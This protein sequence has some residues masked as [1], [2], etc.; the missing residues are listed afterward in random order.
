MGYQEI[1]AITMCLEIVEIG[2][3]MRLNLLRNKP[4]EYSVSFDE[5]LIDLNYQRVYYMLRFLVPVSMIMWIVSFGIGDTEKIQQTNGILF[6]S[7]AVLFL[8]SLKYPLQALQDDRYAKK[9]IIYTTYAVLLYWGTDLYGF[10]DN[11]Q[12]LLLDMIL[13]IVVIAFIFVTS[14]QVIAMYYLTNLFYLFGMTPYLEGAMDYLP[15]IV[16]PI[17]LAITAFF[18][19]RI[20]Y[21]QHIERYI[22]QE[23]LKVKQETLTE[24]LFETMVKLKSTEQDIR[25][26]VIKTLLKV[27]EYYDQ[28]TRGHSEN[29]SNYALKIA[30]KMGL[31]ESIQDE[32]MVCGLVHDIGKI[33]IPV[34]ILNK[35]GQ[36]DA[37]EYEVIKKHSQYGSDMLMESKHLHRIAKIVLHHHERWDGKGYPHRLKREAIPIESQI[38]MVADTWDAM[39]SERSYKPAKTFEEAKTEMLN[40]KGKQFPPDIVDLLLSIVE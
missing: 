22:L 8:S 16:T 2:A 40:L 30:Q 21:Q 9:W 11:N 31:D 4:I 10:Q 27:L 24:E 19:S 28:Y 39:I 17:L 29:V 15:K 6:L 18:L 36:L 38:L 26:D 12:V 1:V 13:V 20:I 32:I 35:P 23:K 33:L 25:T 14:Y 37:D 34:H 3:Y 7:S 5:S